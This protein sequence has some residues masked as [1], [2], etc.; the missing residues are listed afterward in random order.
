LLALLP[1]RSAGG[2]PPL[3]TWV[4]RSW[5]ISDRLPQ[6]SVNALLQDRD[7][8][9]WAGTFGG[10]TRF[11]GVRF[12]TLRTGEPC[13][14]RVTA[15][16]LAG[17]GAI[18]VGSERSGI[19][20]LSGGVLAPYVP[21]DGRPVTGVSRLRVSGREVFAATDQ[22][23]LR[24]GP[25]RFRRYGPED[26]LAE[27]IVTFVHPEDGG[28]VWAGT[29]GGVQVLA[30][31]RFG[32]PDVEGLPETVVFDA[33]RAPSNGD[34]WLGTLDGLFRVVEGRAEKVVLPE[35]A[36]RV[37]TVLVDRSGVVWAGS[38]LG[39]LVRLRPGS[40]EPPAVVEAVPG[41]VRSLME[42]REGGVWAG[43]QTSGLVRLG[44]G[45]ASSI[46][47]PGSPLG[48]PVVPVVGDGAGG[49]W[50][51]LNCDGVAHVTRDSVRLVEPGP[52]RR[53]GCPWALHRD[54]TGALWVGMHGQG[55]Y[56]LEGDSLVSRGGPPNPD[57]IVRAVAQGGD[58][59][60]LVGTGAGLY[61]HDVA[62]GAFTLVAGSEGLDVFAVV[63]FPDGTVGIG[64]QTGPWLLRGDGVER[65]ASGRVPDVPVRAIHR[66]GTGATWL[67][68]YGHGLFRVAG[69][70]V[71]RLGG[72]QGLFEE[73]VSRVVEDSRGR[74]WMT[75]NRGVSVVA[76]AELEAVAAGREARAEAVLLGAPEGMRTP[77][78]NG[79]GQ[80]AGWLDEGGTFWVPTVDGLA[81]FDTAADLGGQAPLAVRV[82]GVRAGGRDY[83]PASE[84]RFPPGV[85]RIEI[86]Y[87]APSFSGQERIRFF[88]RLEG[89]DADW[90]DVGSRRQANLAL[91][92]PGAYAFEVAARRPGGPLVPAASP[93]RFVV[94][95]RFVETW[96]FRL[97]SGLAAALVVATAVS[98]RVAI[99]RRRERQLERD[100]AARTAELEKLGELTRLVSEAETL[101]EALDH[102]YETFHEAV[103]YDRI[104]YALVDEAR[105]LV[106]AVWARSASP[107]TE[108]P[109]GYTSTLSGSSLSKVLET[110]E[111]RILPDL[112]AYLLAHP[113]SDSTR[114]IVAD[115]MRSSLTCPLRA[116]G[117]PVAF[118][119]FSSTRP[120]A[121]D[122][123]HV[124]FLRQI[125]GQ[126]SLVLD[127]TRLLDELVSAKA[128]LEAA[129]RELAS[130]A[131]TDSLTGL[132]NRRA[133][134]EAL[135]SEWRR[136]SRTE[137]VLSFL[138]VDVDHFKAYN[139]L[140]GHTKGDECLRMVARA[141]A[142]TLRR[143]GELVARYGGEEFAVILPDTG[144]EEA[145]QVAGRLRERVA[146]LALPHAGSSVAATVTVSVGAA[147]VVASR[148]G[149]PQA[150][151][152]A[153]DAA[154]YEAKE[155][156]RNRVVHRPAD[157]AGWSG[158]LRRRDAGQS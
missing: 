16:A 113:S 102:V 32:P 58:G 53:T 14:G 109:A 15:L 88:H 23:L 57:G 66:D 91:L 43:T 54:R 151:V 89:V 87:A 86:R 25:D 92:P 153:A 96:L 77:E 114:R 158:G 34:L 142:G 107:G 9:V 154:L 122:A 157:L 81:L 72:A 73:H 6:S 76:R 78:C 24:I 99:A 35:G 141:L 148:S 42:D 135:R 50:V 129:N 106:R 12:E 48:M 55:L 140:Y 112:E 30:G 39:R 85:T 130:L 97:L 40:G 51:G 68:T 28:R 21:P 65:L 69:Q 103:P 116:R 156:G 80:P 111:P 67:G 150:L 31:N 101:E 38:D 84:I 22:G 128:S 5:S 83:D 136:A 71:A 94:E 26:G 47:G 137:L 10:L 105:G 17:D 144:A 121:Y 133:F 36:R 134:D 139:D 120:G 119:F 62:S 56:R 37:V 125:A 127:K 52:G 70:E 132:A 131:T 60:L 27:A 3:E 110:G 82:E 8:Y 33:A 117:R 46:G 95:P 146:A 41:G 1:E 11:D 61:R 124:R 20:V 100:V 19:C 143:A 75:G 118:L 49:V 74:L 98:A 108:L 59:T 7:G 64:T 152:A 29:K 149:D 155:L 45:I 13:A 147:S 63:P 123:S 18:W 126:L 145:L 104:G 115:G 79:G 138:L 44:R 93:V 4:P 90:V 2:A